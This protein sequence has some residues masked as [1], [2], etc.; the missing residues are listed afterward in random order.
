MSKPLNEMFEEAIGRISQRI[1]TAEEEFLR[2]AGERL[3]SIGGLTSEEA[4]KYLFSNESGFDQQS[5]L[6]KIKKALLAAHNANIR[7]LNDLY[8]DIGDAVE[9]DIDMEVPRKPKENDPMLK[10]ALALYTSMAASSIIGDTYK[11]S[12]NRLVNGMIGDDKR[13]SYASNMR[14][15]VRELAENGITALDP[16]TGQRVN[17]EAAIHSQI[18]TEFFDMAKAME[19]EA[20]GGEITGWEI[21]AHFAPAKDHEDIQG[22]IFTNEEFEK[23]QNHEEA[24]DIDGEAFQLDR[25]IG[26]WNC[27]HYPRPFIIG[28]SEPRCSQEE[29]DEIKRQNEEGIEFNGEH[30][31]LYEADQLHWQYEREI[32]KEKRIGILSKP[33]KDSDLALQLDYQR[34]QK[35]LL[36]HRVKYYELGEK[37]GYATFQERVEY[38]FGTKVKWDNVIPGKEYTVTDLFKSALKDEGNNFTPLARAFQSHNQINNPNRNSTFIAPK[39]TNPIENTKF[40]LAYLQKLFNSGK[41]EYEFEHDKVME[42]P[43]GK[44]VIGVVKIRLPTGEGAMWSIDGKHFLGFRSISKGE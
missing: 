25:A 23:L 4:R 40:G 10:T 42:L 36:Y 11:K 6:N 13:I 44:K 19:R 35:R 28:V 26:D 17:M 43:G 16:K 38:S 33:G 14:K 20:A 27:Q 29:L 1:T 37:L 3:K 32:Q 39:S 5:D 34:Q 7:S 31:T 9:D 2:I 30:Y 21:S 12:M 18:K 22:H 41:I 15:A 8:D 24:H